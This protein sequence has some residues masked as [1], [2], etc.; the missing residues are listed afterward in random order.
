MQNSRHG[1]ENRENEAPLPASKLA[2][3]PQS[4]IGK[5]RGLSPIFTRDWSTSPAGASLKSAI[6]TQATVD[7][8][9]LAKKVF[10][11]DTPQPNRLRAFGQGNC[12][13]AN[14]VDRSK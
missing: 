5:N 9:V 13:N 4:I 8:P 11:P 14:V 7:S 12:M 10:T 3:K 6:S 2:E 1:N